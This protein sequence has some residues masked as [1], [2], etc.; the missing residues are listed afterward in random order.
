MQDNGS[1]RNLMMFAAAR[2]GTVSQSATPQP[3][4]IRKPLTK[5]KAP[6][7]TQY[8]YSRLDKYCECGYRY[9][10]TYEDG[11]YI[12]E[13]GIAAAIGTLVHYTEEQIA[14]HIMA[15][16]PIPYEDLK[17]TF[18][19]INIPE[20]K[21]EYDASGH[22]KKGSEGGIYG[23]NE[24]KKRFG[25]EF[26][27][28]DRQGTTFAQKCS[29]YLSSGIYRLQQRMD[30]HP[31]L[32]IVGVEVEFFCEFEGNALHGYIDRVLRNKDTGEYILEDIK[33]KGKPF[34]EEKLKTPLQFIV[35]SIAAAKLYDLQDYPTSFNY[36]LPFCNLIQ[37]AGTKGCLTRGFT[38]LEKIFSGIEEK[39]FV[40]HP[41][42]LCYWCEFCDNNPHRPEAGK[43]MCPYYSLWT[44]D[45]THKSYETNRK[46][47]GQEKHQSIL[48]A[49]RAQYGLHRASPGVIEDFGL[50][51][52]G[53]GAKG[54]KTNGF[55]DFDF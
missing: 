33:T 4:V 21:A 16:E 30:S 32:E 49:Y 43:A 42:A 25:K 35:Y 22:K 7:K 10:L 8:S 50:D 19:E 6:R 36:D 27:E 11:N 13:A 48:E 44:P 46:W 55:D 2:C 12:D 45:G 38:K 52:P 26:Y 23:I 29:E 14:K 34:D 28:L 3:P 51:S 39:K 9:K 1:L 40:P 24:I 5:A 20:K 54:T 31:E 17:K 47:E 18:M 53:T 15:G 41:T 37:P